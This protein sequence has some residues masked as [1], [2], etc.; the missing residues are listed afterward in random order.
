MLGTPSFRFSIQTALAASLLTTGLM[1]SG[2]GEPVLLSTPVVVEIDRTENDI[3]TRLNAIDDVTAYEISTSLPDYRAF[4]VT[5]EQPQVHGSVGGATF[6]QR[7]LLLHR[8]DDAPM[9]AATTGYDLFG[10]PDV[11]ADYRGEVTRLTNGNQLMI[12]HR[13]FGESIPDANVRDWEALTVQ[14]AA[15]DSH[16]MRVLLGEIYSGAWIGTGVSKGGMTA[17]FHHTYFPDDLDGIVPYVAP[18]SFGMEDFRYLEFLRNIGPDD[19]ACAA[20]VRGIALALLERIDEIAPLAAQYSPGAAGLKDDVV[21]ASAGQNAF[22]LEWSFW[23]SWGSQQA[24]DALPAPDGAAEDLAPFAIFSA[25][26]SL[27]LYENTLA[28]YSYQVAYELGSQG[29]DYGELT[30]YL[31]SLPWDAL[32]PGPPPPWNAYPAF[33]GQTMVDVDTFMRTEAENVLAVYGEWDP[34][35][36]GKITIDENN[37]NNH[38]LVAPGVGHAARISMLSESDK[39]TALAALSD[40]AGVELDVSTLNDESVVFSGPSSL[41]GLSALVADP[42]TRRTLLV[43]EALKRAEREVRLKTQ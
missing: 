41:A 23:Q 8:A 35:T 29:F 11:W 25:T 40:M 5:I 31:D 15:A 24:C 27:G 4:S 20:N 37:N 9:I 13:F 14:N 36:A 17:I 39:A 32:L 6:S 22:G 38:L 30:P 26:N 34:W 42:L 10:G 3:L 21:L 2:C 16:K 19:G 28:P 43:E 33:N 18:I 1:T 12:E 7:M